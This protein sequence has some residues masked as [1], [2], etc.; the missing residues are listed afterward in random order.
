MSAVELTSCIK[1]GV[2]VK[3]INTQKRSLLKDICDAKRLTSAATNALEKST[4]KM[5]ALDTKYRVLLDTSKIQQDSI[6]QL[7]VANAKTIK[8]LKVTTKKIDLQLSAKL[9][10]QKEKAQLALEKER[11]GLER[12]NAKKKKEQIIKLTHKQRVRLHKFKLKCAASAAETK[13]AVKSME[14]QDNLA[15][16]AL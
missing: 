9:E 5:V 1:M 2:A 12:D 7:K 6:K 14:K 11:I 3:E 15:Q 10:S 4:N 16:S 8:E 13:F